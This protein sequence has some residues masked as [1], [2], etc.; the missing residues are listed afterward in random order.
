MKKYI[1]PEMA[2]ALFD[3][4]KIVTVSGEYPTNFR[5]LKTKVNEKEGTDYGTQEV[6]IFSNN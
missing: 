4:E 6:S 3:T 1:K 2:L 5:M